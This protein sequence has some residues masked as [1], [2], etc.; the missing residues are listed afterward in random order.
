MRWLSAL[1]RHKIRDREIE[2]ELRF[3]LDQ[4][5]VDYVARGLSREEAHRRAR[6]EFG[7]VPQVKRQCRDVWSLPWLRDVRQDARFASRS[8]L[9]ARGFTGVAIAT[10]GAGLTLSVVMLTIVNAYFIRPLPYPAAERLFTVQYAPPGYDAPGNL[11]ALDWQSLDDVL[12]HPIAWDLDMF[13]LMG[14]ARP[15]RAP[16]AWV[17]PGF[18]EG[19]GVRPMI[20]RVRP[21]GGS[22]VT[23]WTVIEPSSS[24]WWSWRHPYT[25]S[26]QRRGASSRR[27]DRA[28]SAGPAGRYRSRHAAEE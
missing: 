17:T 9:K 20:G 10:L 8:L 2:K 16:G 28:L 14:G 22:A 19:F 5:A 7:G 21:H 1:R 4:R 26:I 15:E 11:R 18:I 6:A 25:N 12:E 24:V 27:G 3:H 13:Y 23:M